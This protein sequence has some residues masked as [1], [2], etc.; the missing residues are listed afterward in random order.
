[1]AG[2]TDFSGRVVVVTGGASGIG[3]GIAAQFGQRG[4]EVV[5]ADIDGDAL[6]Q[7]TH[8]IGATAV[9]TDVTSPESV[10]QLAASVLRAQGRVDIVCNNAGVGPRAT[11]ENLTLAD[12]EWVLRVNLF[13][14][15]HGIHAFL[16]H[17]TANPDGGWIVNTASM[18]AFVTTPGYA[19]YSASKSAVNGLSLVLR[20]EL[21][22]A[23]HRVGVTVLH[24][25]YVR[26][27]IKESLRH[28]PDHLT[29][30]SG[31]VDFD[32]AERLP[33]TVRWATPDDTGR[34]VVRAVENG[35]TYAFTH[36]EL[37][38]EVQVQ[39]QAVES[40]MT[41]YPVQARAVVFDAPGGPDVLHVADVP[42]PEPGEAET[43]IQVAAAAVHPTDPARRAGAWPLTG[44]P[45]H[46][47]G[48]AIA[49][50]VED[51]GPGSRWQAGDR[52]MAMMLPFSPYGGGYVAAV[53]APDD[54]IARAPEG[55]DLATAATL[56]MNGHTALQ[57]L[58]LIDLSPGET[59]A[60]TG[61]AGAL[62]AIVIPLAV[63]A[64]LV[65][66]ADA[67]PDD[68]DL[69]AALGPQIIV[70]RGDDVVQHI[71]AV[72][73]DGVDG[74]ID[75]ATLNERMVPAVR[76]GGV[77]ASLR[78]WTAELPRG[79]RVHPVAV[80]DDWHRASQL[81]RL[82]ALI[83]AGTLV[84]RQLR[85]FAPA[86]APTAHRLIEAGGVRTGIVIDFESAHDD[87]AAEPGP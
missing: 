73:P 65:V 61:A 68:H 6:D 10:E 52:V 18:A 30:E 66:I 47:P 4:A 14:V 46:V 72:R 82:T 55:A 53:I 86:D 32:L 23:G 34:I 45:P 41:T 22:Q 48:M 42:V 59:V 28:R 84:P 64:G 71:R 62:G 33:P 11:I 74:L 58:R 7:A 31:L 80:S 26:T 2:I 37:I 57:A 39:F 76:D 75:A 50:V 69:V 56:P 63:D 21:E 13:G 1:M 83:E 35:D 87:T 77:I 16:P 38:R 24:P 78:G 5:I 79:I 60:V 15:I 36:P 49:G 25:G 81:D 70:P 51:V 85:R 20:R 44:D 9:Q 67:S 43:R 29:G 17:L 40:A 54:T 3:R 19:P 27:N 12:W 8:E